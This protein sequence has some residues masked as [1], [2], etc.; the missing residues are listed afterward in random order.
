[1]QCTK[2]VMIERIANLWVGW[3]HQRF[4]T[5]QNRS[6]ANELIPRMTGME[7]TTEY[8]YWKKQGFVFYSRR[9]LFC[10]AEGNE[11]DEVKSSNALRCD[12]AMWYWMLCG[13]VKLQRMDLKNSRCFYFRNI[14]NKTSRICWASHPIISKLNFLRS[15]VLPFEAVQIEALQVPY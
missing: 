13:L 11:D 9:T 4:M 7:C 14:C 6:E 1:M 5:S 10:I 3:D 8:V 2:S 15:L 12:H